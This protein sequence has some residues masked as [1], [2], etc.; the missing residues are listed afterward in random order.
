[1]FVIIKAP[2]WPLMWFTHILASIS[3]QL[4]NAVRP[5]LTPYLHKPLSP[6]L[7]RQK[8]ADTG[9]KEDQQATV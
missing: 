9:H 7:L 8:E 4:H 6:T 5:V 2:W 3:D 1:M